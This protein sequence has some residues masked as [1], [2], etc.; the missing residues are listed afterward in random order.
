MSSSEDIVD[1]VE[2]NSQNTKLCLICA[3]DFESSER[4]YCIGFCGHDDVC[5]SCFFRVRLLQK[6]FCCPSCKQHLEYVITT[7]SN[8]DKFSSLNVLKNNI[9]AGYAYDQKS[10]MYFPS[11]YYK[12]T[13][14]TMLLYKG[15]S[16]TGKALDAESMGKHLREHDSVLCGLCIKNK[17]C[18]S[19]EQ[20][21]Y[22]QAEYAD[23]LRIG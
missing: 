17:Q 6:S 3:S 22:N 8:E 23:H 9:A 14:K 13:I 7:D 4:L 15:S 2:E 20:R 16:C 5:S 21:V 19:S 18:F 10:Q 11:S 12:T 1:R